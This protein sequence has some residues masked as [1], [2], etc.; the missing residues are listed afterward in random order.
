MFE[1]VQRITLKELLNN[2]YYRKKSDPERSCRMD[3]T[4]VNIQGIE[5]SIN[6]INN[7]CKSS[8]V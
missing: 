6:I 5:I 7:D 1:E 8:Y 3:K 2:V 4:M